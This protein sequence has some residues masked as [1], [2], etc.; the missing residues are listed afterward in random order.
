FSRFHETLSLIKTV[1][2][3]VMED[4][5]RDRFLNEVAATQVVVRHG[6]LSDGFFNAGK[7]LA[8][9]AGR[10][11]VLAFGAVLIFKHQTTLGT[12]VAFLSYYA[13][14]QGPVEGLAKL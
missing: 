11:A 9:A 5:E 6:V 14:L 1:K 10:I 2:S 7:N 13:G 8:L 4:R 12:L 3:F